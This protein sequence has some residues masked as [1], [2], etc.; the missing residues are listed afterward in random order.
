MITAIAIDDEPM[1]LGLIQAY[2]AKLPELDLRKTFTR[3]SEARQYLQDFPVDLIFLD[4]RMPDISGIE[5]YKAAGKDTLVIFTTAFTEYA[6]TG[7]DLKAV[8]YLLKPFTFDRFAQAITQAQAHLQLRRSTP[9]ESPRTLQVRAEYS[10]VNIP[11]TDI[12]YIET[13]DDYLKIHLEDRKPIITLMRMRQ[14]EEKLP[15]KEFIRIHRSFIVPIRRITAVRNKTV[16]LPGLEI[17]IG[18]TFE[19]AFWQAYRTT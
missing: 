10:L 12:L 15:Q 4:I 2:A 16:F 5:F 14:M 9:P 7:F 13:M 3:P 19:S 8:D 18:A 11:L 6:V 1:A 17:P